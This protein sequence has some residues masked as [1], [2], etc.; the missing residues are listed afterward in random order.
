M[1]T[2]TR[3]SGGK[4]I[5]LACAS[6]MCL[7]WSVMSM[8]T[9]STQ[10]QRHTAVPKMPEAQPDLS[11]CQPAST[12]LHVLAASITPPW[13]WADWKESTCPEGMMPYKMQTAVNLGLN[14]GA[15][16]FRNVCCKIKVAYK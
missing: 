16:Y 11:Q 9:D 1:N 14:N 12:N 13:E 8:A 4:L 5:L 7:S 10:M 15:Y 3:M 2:K 6:V